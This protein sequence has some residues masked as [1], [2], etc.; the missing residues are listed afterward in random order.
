MTCRNCQ[1]RNVTWH[2]SVYSMLTRR[3][4]LTL[5]I[6]S[7]TK[8]F[9]SSHALTVREK[10]GAK[11]T[12]FRFTTPRGSVYEY[13]LENKN[14]VDCITSERMA[15]E[16][17]EK[18]RKKVEERRNRQGEFFFG[19]P[20]SDDVP[21]F[22]HSYVEI[23]SASGFSDDGGLLYAEY[24]VDKPKGWTGV[25]Q[26]PGIN[27][28]GVEP[29]DNQDR[30]TTQL[31]RPI[32][33]KPKISTKKEGVQMAGYK[34]FGTSS[35]P[36]GDHFVEGEVGRF[37]GV[38]LFITV[39]CG[40]L[41]GEEYLFWLFS[42]LM[43]FAMII[44]VSP[45]GQ[46]D[47]VIAEPVYHFGYPVSFHFAPPSDYFSDPVAQS[48]Q[49]MML[50]QVSSKHNFQRH[51]IEGYGYVKV[52]TKPGSYDFTVNTW[53]PVGGISSE[54]RN[55]FIGGAYKLH[56]L[57]S[58]VMSG[59]SGGSFL[60]KFGF[61]TV[62]SGQLRIRMQVVAH[63]QPLAVTEEGSENSGEKTG[64]V[65]NR[66]SIDGILT[67]VRKARGERGTGTKEPTSPLRRRSE[68]L[69][70]SASG[71]LRDLNTTASSTLNMTKTIDSESTGFGGEHMTGY[72]RTGD[73]LL[74]VKARRE[75]REKAKEGKSLK[76]GGGRARKER[77]V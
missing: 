6:F 10:D 17:S 30:G 69:E 22:L 21:F 35:A 15:A 34:Q 51:I 39:I 5:T 45:S 55:F 48:Q 56:S 60:S 28:G 40:L 38:V 31:S 33:L 18:D 67:R 52:P 47:H 9:A 29:I 32:Y 54:V 24:E 2:R 59:K 77:D 4:R 68:M 57:K 53:V 73:V 72:E 26:C 58:V 37:L 75:A 8:T 66:G 64:G 76:E 27:W 61:R 13:A 7:Q 65:D 49:P 20:I 50:F 16:Q 25:N 19:A 12:T 23:V 70:R 63:K 14:S 3:L 71:S 43:L 36:R 11:L 1:T 44:G 46:Y 74:R 41:L 62:K 42:A